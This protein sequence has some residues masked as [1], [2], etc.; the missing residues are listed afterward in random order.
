MAKRIYNFDT[1]GK[2][3]TYRLDG[4]I[5]R[6]QAYKDQITYRAYVFI[7]G[8]L[9]FPLLWPNPLIER[10]QAELARGKNAGRKKRATKVEMSLRPKIEKRVRR[11]K[12]MLAPWELKKTI[13]K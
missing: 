6:N 5:A 12:D 2:I 13:V 7:C 1:D 3:K 10:E 8:Q 11:T 4:P 9:G